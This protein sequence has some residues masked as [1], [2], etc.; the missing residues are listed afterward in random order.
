[1]NT[2]KILKSMRAKKGYTQAEFANIINVS[3][4]IYNSYENNP[5]S[6]PLNLL[7]K[8]IKALD[9]NIEEFLFALEQDYLSCKDLKNEQSKIQN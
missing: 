7:F 9:G 5:I 3:R 4:Q 2:Q 8:I 1:M 6:C